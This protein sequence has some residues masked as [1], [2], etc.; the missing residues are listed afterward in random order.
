MQY[1]LKRITLKSIFMKR[2]NWILILLVAFCGA[3][4]SESCKNKKKTEPTTQE[5]KKTDAPVEVSSDAT[6]RVSVD[7]VIKEYEGVQADIKDG[8]VT[9]RGNI[10]QSDLQNLIMKI[11]ELKPKKV[12][13]QLVI[14]V[15]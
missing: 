4:I 8:V 1:F 15:N 14:K 2:K 10:K 12:E 5:E 3:T 13:N 11:Q 7:N 6:L 9:L